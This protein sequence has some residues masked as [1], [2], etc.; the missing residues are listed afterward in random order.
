MPPCGHYET[1]ES[2]RGELAA[3]FLVILSGFVHVTL[4]TVRGF[5]NATV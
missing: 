5:V 2:R 1:F 4:V 3:V